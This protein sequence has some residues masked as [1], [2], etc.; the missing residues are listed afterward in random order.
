LVKNLFY[1]ILFQDGEVEDLSTKILA[2]KDE[3]SL[4]KTKAQTLGEELSESKQQFRCDIAEKDSQLTNLKACIL[5]LE[6]AKKKLE[7]ELEEQVSKN[8]YSR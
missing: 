1:F 2:L 4:A 5:D 6:M 8:F 7:S 3:L